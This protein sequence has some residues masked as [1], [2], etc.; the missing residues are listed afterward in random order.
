MRIK[1]KSSKLFIEGRRGGAESAEVHQKQKR[2]H[3]SKVSLDKISLNYTELAVI[4]SKTNAKTQAHTIS[5]HICIKID[6]QL[7]LP[8]SLYVGTVIPCLTAHYDH[9]FD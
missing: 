1:T 7:S 9:F 6:N 5:F 3:L 8:V 4:L 2:K